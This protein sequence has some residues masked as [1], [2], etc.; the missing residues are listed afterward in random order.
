M[1]RWSWWLWLLPVTGQFT[2]I[3]ESNGELAGTKLIARLYPTDDFGMDLVNDTPLVGVV[4]YDQGA[5]YGTSLIADG[6][7]PLPGC[8]PGTSIRD[9]HTNQR[10][11]YVK[12][13][14]KIAYAA[15]DNNCQDRE[16]WISAYAYGTAANM[17]RIDINPG[18][19]SSL[20]KNLV[21]HGTYATFTANDGHGR[22]HWMT[23][24]TV[25]GTHKVSS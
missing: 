21:S 22:A 17:I 1:L 16:L 7:Y 5:A 3:W 19:N 2:Y 13:G 12:I 4:S 15:S 20:I 6:G 14:R 24:G 8:D 10:P 9:P 18:S 23:D 25:K 11:L